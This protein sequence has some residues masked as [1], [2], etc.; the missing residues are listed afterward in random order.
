MKGHR[1]VDEVLS[2]FEKFQKSTCE[3]FRNNV[4]ENGEF[5]SIFKY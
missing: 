2:K 3:V 4:G 5:K 1:R